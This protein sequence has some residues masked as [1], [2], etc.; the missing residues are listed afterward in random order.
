MEMKEANACVWLQGSAV[1]GCVYIAGLSS[2][3]TLQGLALSLAESRRVAGR[4][5]QR[6]RGHSKPLPSSR[7]RSA[8][9]R[10]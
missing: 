4:L 9:V 3:G 6:G 8:S 1:S 5:K 2:R 7:D 10:L